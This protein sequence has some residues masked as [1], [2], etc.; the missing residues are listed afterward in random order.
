MDVTKD[1]PESGV[2]WFSPHA[3]LL[4]QAGP[5]PVGVSVTPGCC[6][7]CRG[8]G[9]ALGKAELRAA[10]HLCPTGTACWWF[11]VQSVPIV[12]CHEPGNGTFLSPLPAHWPFVSGFELK[13]AQKV[14]I[15]TEILK[16]SPEIRHRI[17]VAVEWG[18]GS[19]SFKLF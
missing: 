5:S 12:S 11:G 13:R 9:S 7:N 2:E 15:I 16:D 10:P 14:Q 4:P 18:S 6:Q 1:T 19:E 8:A 3:A 17:P